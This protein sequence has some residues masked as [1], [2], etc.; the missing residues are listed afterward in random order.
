M[1]KV[2]NIEK[3]L[4]KKEKITKDLAKRCEWQDREI[5]RLLGLLK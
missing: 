2:S 3:L 5:D 1:E 4:K